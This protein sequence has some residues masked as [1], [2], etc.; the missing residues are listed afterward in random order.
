MRAQ[1]PPVGNSKA[2]RDAERMSV[3][4]RQKAQ[5]GRRSGVRL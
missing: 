5:I 2:W 3:E 4:G 1:M